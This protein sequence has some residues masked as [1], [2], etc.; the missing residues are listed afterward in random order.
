MPYDNRIHLMGNLG[1]TPELRHFTNGNAVTT[2][3]VAYTEKWTD[4]NSHEPRERT[5]WFTVHLYGRHA[6][7]VCKFMKSGDCIAVWGRLKNRNYTDKSGIERNVVEIEAD[8][9]Q[10][11]RTKQAAAPEA[12]HPA[13][14][15][16]SYM[17]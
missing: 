4:K 13:T 15:G 7:T 17:E 3:S 5:D 14:G 6:E 2:V 9:M 11:I 1:K 8:D 16:T 10:I 12:E